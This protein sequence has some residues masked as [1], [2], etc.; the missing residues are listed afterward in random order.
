MT[1]EALAEV[2]HIPLGHVMVMDPWK[3]ARLERLAEIA[4]AV[5]R[6]ER[7]EG[8]RPPGVLIDPRRRR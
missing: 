7:G 3:R 4:E 2:L 6:W 5:M 1:D 8:P